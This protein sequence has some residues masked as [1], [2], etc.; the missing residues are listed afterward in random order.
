MECEDYKVVYPEDACRLDQNEEFFEL[1]TEECKKR[2]LIHEYEK[3]YEVPGLYEEVVYNRLQCDSP[4]MM[5]SMLEREIGPRMDV[6][7]SLRVLDFGAGNGMAAEC[8]A[9]KFE[10]KAMVGLDIIPEA[11]EAARRDRPD[12]YDAYYVMDLSQPSSDDL[13]KLDR[14]KFNAL[15]TVAALGYG[16][17]PTQGFINA[18]NLVEDGGLVAFNIKDRFMSDD[19]DTGYRDTIQAMMG[20]SFETFRVQN[21][22]HRLS[23]SGEPLHYN[24]V[25]GRKLKDV[26]PEMIPS[27]A[28]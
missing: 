3:L 6:E 9:E 8:L 26:P 19:D 28:S 15:L 14:W 25:V 16:D 12:V 24:A 11:K 2:L 21:Y 1:V 18:F 22:C 20:E 7:K 5:C 27:T 23:M 13:Q 10:C 4:R 17:I